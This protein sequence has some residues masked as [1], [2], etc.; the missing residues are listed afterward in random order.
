MIEL[1]AEAHRARHRNRRTD[2]ERARLVAGG[3][4]DAA[5]LGIAAD[6]DRTSAQL[7]LVALLNGRVEGVHVDVQ[8]AAHEKG[9]AY[10]LLSRPSSQPSG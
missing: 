7:R 1:R 8:D 10:L 2:A 6:G 3:R 5:L 9:T 4:D